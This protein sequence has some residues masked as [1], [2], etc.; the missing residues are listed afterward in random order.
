MPKT[1]EIYRTNG[2][3]WLVAGRG[4][5]F[6]GAH[7]MTKNAALQAAHERHPGATIEVVKEDRP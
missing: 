5:A 1:V 4:V 2:G 6:L 3:W 7:P